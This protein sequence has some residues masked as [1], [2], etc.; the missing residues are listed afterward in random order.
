MSRRLLMWEIDCRDGADVDEIRKL[1]DKHRLAP[2]R[3]DARPS[4]HGARGTGSP[5]DPRYL[6]RVFEATPTMTRVLA[7]SPAATALVVAMPIDGKPA[8]EFL[9][10]AREDKELVKVPL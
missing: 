5:G 8:Q 3:A 7:M 2:A 10:M 9:A 1:I 6:L 4:C